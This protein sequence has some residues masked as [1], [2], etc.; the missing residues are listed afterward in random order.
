MQMSNILVSYH[1]HVNLPQ[2]LPPKVQQEK[3]INAIQ[4]DPRLIQLIGSREVLEIHRMDSDGCRSYQVV[5][6]GFT[7][8]VDVYYLPPERPIC[9]PAKFELFFHLPDFQDRP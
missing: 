2:A 5:G 3:E 4:N 6:E 9:G 1:Q 8:Q 7:L